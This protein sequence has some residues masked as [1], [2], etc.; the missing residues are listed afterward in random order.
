M[1]KG[2]VW[3]KKV[4]KYISSFHSI[5]YVLTHAIKMQLFWLQLK[6]NDVLSRVL[7]FDYLNY[8][9]YYFDII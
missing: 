4:N 3:K 7:I 8:Y 5:V 9:Y 6:A 1:T 2:I